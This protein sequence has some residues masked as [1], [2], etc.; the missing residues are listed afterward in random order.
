[1]KRLLIVPLATLL[2]LSAAIAGGDAETR[3]MIAIHTDTLGLVEMDLSD[4]QLGESRTVTTEDGHVVDALV[5]AEGIEIYVDGELLEMPRA[6]APPAPPAIPGTPE[7]PEAPAAPRYSW[8][9]SEDHDIHIECTDVDETECRER[10]VFVFSGEPG[11]MEFSD[12][13]DHEMHFEHG[14]TIEQIVEEDDDGRKVII[15]RERHVA[16]ED[17]I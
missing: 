2:G 9:S 13:F 1:M 16:P 8:H 15:I 11:E 7:A 12:G 17:E 10:H 5:T 6:P 14:V 4:L 3:R